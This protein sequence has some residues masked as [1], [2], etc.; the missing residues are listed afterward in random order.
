MLIGAR[1]DFTEEVEER[2]YDLATVNSSHKDVGNK[3][4][5]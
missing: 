2:N 1:N 4:I 3:P 5:S